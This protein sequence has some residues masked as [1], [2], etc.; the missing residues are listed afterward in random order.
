MILPEIRQCGEEL[1]RK[2]YAGV[3]TSHLLIA[4][5]IMTKQNHTMVNKSEPSHHNDDNAYESISPDKRRVA[6]GQSDGAHH[7]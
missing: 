6:K 2:K 4:T 3:E 1:A 7:E 5:K